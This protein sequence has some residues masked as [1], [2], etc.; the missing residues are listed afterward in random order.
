M[1]ASLNTK[2]LEKTLLNITKYSLG[3]IEGTNRGKKIF[4]ENL[5][6]GVIDALSYYIDS[7][8]R[9]NKEALHHV[10]EWY[11]TGSPDAR[12]FNIKYTISNLG[13][14]VNSTFSQ[15]RSISNNSKEPF[16]DKA[17]IMEKG[18]PI[19]I[20]PSANG[21]LAFEKDGTMIF[22]KK[23]IN[24][25]NPGGTEVAGSYEKVFDSFFGKYFTQAFLRASGLYS[26]IENPKIYKKN[27]PAGSKQGRSQGIKTGYTWIINAKIGVDNA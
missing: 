24:I 13:L 25:K 9:M 5:G 15:S 4:L 21:V 1:R 2:E 27:F 7:N 22:T 16:Y 12:L 23:T 8:A 6:R 19:T 26:Y 20:S 18:V 11:Q 14:S 17:R 3:F 10:Y